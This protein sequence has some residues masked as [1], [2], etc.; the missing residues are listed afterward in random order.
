MDKYII[1][2][3]N[4]KCFSFFCDLWKL[5]K[6]TRNMILLMLWVGKRCIFC[7]FVRLQLRT[8]VTKF[9]HEYIIRCCLIKYKQ[10]LNTQIRSAIKLLGNAL[11]CFLFI[12]RKRKKKNFSI[13]GFSWI[14]FC[15]L[16]VFLVTAS[17]I[18]VPVKY[19]YVYQNVLVMTVSVSMLL[20]FSRW[21]QNQ[22]TNK[23]NVFTCYT[24]M[25]TLSISFGISSEVSVL[26]LFHL[27]LLLVH[28]CRVFSFFSLHLIN[29]QKPIFLLQ[30]FFQLISKM[31]KLIFLF[32]KSSS[33]LI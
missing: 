10:I 28:S 31:E 27:L 5:N 12:C 19:I 32:D 20:N 22:R 7:L 30:F 14:Y 24:S 26:F 8:S 29:T 16:V 21:A 2:F 1:T 23:I 17:I 25:R 11:F 18:Q 15:F 6:N 4:I 3:T 33:S 9:C 13:C